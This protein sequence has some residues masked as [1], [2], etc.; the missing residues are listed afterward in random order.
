MD[1]SIVIPVYNEE[2]NVEPLVQ[3]LKAVLEGKQAEI[4][5]VDDGSRDGTFHRLEQ[6]QQPGLTVVQLRRNY[7]KTPALMAGFMRA[8]G[9]IIVTMDG[10]LQEEPEEIPHLLA[11]LD[12]GYDV[13]SGWRHQRKDPLT[14]KLASRFSNTLT[15]WLTGLKLHDFNCG[16]KAYRREAIKDLTL[17]GEMHRYIPALLNWEGFR[18]TEAK[19]THHP[20][21][22]G[23]SKFGFSRLLRGLLDLMYL[24]YLIKYADKP[25]YIF[26]S[27]GTA[28]IVAGVVVGVYLIMLRL[29]YQQEIGDRPLLL[30]AVLLTLMGAQFLTLGFVSGTMVKARYEAGEQG[31]VVRQVLGSAEKRRARKQGER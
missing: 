5:I 9:D 22:H 12:Q 18:V 16:F 30:L 29:L 11:A 20:R 6:L 24:K 15:R 14:K 7:G 19:V 3:R 31:Y 17:Y 13:V 21:Q 27:L 25:M 1:L 8:R 23:T 10:D 26:G 2:E 4:I 28:S